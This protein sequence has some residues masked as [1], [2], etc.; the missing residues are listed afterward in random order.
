MSGRLQLFAAR[1]LPRWPRRWAFISVVAHATTGVYSNT[2][3][4]ELGA[5]EALKRWEAA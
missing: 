4:P 3:V 2:I 1:C 5:M